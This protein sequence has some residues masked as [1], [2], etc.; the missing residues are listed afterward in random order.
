V[1]HGRSGAG[2]RMT[3]EAVAE[4]RGHEGEAWHGGAVTALRRG[5]DDDFL[6][7][8]QV[9]LASECRAP[10]TSPQRLAYLACAWCAWCGALLTMR[11]LCHYE[12]AV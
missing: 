5:C 8:A 11:V 2:Q 7:S 4:R 12:G 1:K 3:E 9:P 10:A 6:S